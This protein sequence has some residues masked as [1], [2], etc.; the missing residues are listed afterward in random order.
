MREPDATSPH[1]LDASAPASEA[2]SPP[3]DASPPPPDPAPPPLD[4][5]L[6]TALYYP[7]ELEEAVDRFYRRILGLRR[8]GHSAG[9]FLFY[10]VGSEVLLLFNP[11][12]SEAQA[13]PPPHGT[14]GPGHTCFRVPRPEYPRWKSHLESHGVSVEEETE[15]PRGGRS[16]YFRDPAGNALEIAD[17]DIWPP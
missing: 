13:S 14:R 17:G 10:R 8:I 4:G 3:P 7:V 11:E 2:S 9:R 6:E 15:W 1:S 16:F 12:H 5:I